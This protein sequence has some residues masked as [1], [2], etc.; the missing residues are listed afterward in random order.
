MTCWS[1]HAHLGLNLGPSPFH[2]HNVYLV[3]NLMTRLVSPQYHCRFDDFLE[4]VNLNGP[5]VTTSV[6]WKQLVGFCH[7]D[8]TPTALNSL[9]IIDVGILSMEPSKT[10]QSD[11]IEFVKEFEP[12]NDVNIYHEEP[13]NPTQDSEGATP[14]APVLPDASRSSCG[15][16]HKMSR[17]MAKS[18]CQWI[19]Y[20]NRNIHYMATQGISDG[21]TEADLFHDSHLELQYA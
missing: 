16:Q 13:N 1:P 12:N 15:R 6:N 19:F 10:A 5:D 2:A 7:T 18:I 4:T 21:Q 3:L 14:T 20:G 8:G 9:G 17:A 11:P